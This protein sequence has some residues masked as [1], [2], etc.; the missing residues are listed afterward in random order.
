MRNPHPPLLLLFAAP[1]ASAQFCA[2][3][4]SVTL[5]HVKILA[6][7]PVE[8]GAFPAPHSWRPPEEVA[9]NF[10]CAPPDAH[11]PR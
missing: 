1:F 2:S 7:T 10:T 6:A 9:A 11:Q 5:P 8:A 4:A 3:L